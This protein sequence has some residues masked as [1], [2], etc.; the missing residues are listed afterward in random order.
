[1]D[2]WKHLEWKHTWGK[3]TAYVINRNN[4]KSYLIL[5]LA[6]L[7]PRIDLREGISSAFYISL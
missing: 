4:Q 5:I 2:G 1:M 3:V 7:I 6:V